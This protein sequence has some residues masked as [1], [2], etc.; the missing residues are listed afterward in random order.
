MK[1]GFIG[2]GWIGKNMADDFEERGY[3]VV[4]YALEEPYKQNKLKILDCDITFIAVPT[5]TTPAGF[6]C[7]AVRSALT[8]IKAGNT[9]VIK[10]TVLPGTTHQ[11][12]KEFPDITV[13]HSPEFLREKFAA[14]DTRNPK[15][16]IIGIVDV[17]QIG[18][19]EHVLEALPDSQY[20]R[21]IGAE[22]AECV[23]YI[24]N[25]FL[26]T[27]LVFFN[28]MHDMVKDNGG[29]WP[30]V[31]EAVTKDDRIG[32]SHTTVVGNGGKRGAGGHC[33]IKDFAA[34]LTLEGFD[35]DER[36]ALEAIQ[37]VNNNLL[38]LTHKDTDLLADVVG[39]E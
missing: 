36:E 29:Y 39:W 11:L 12:Q 35:E 5:P 10:S 22:S 32:E 34:M 8:L 13:M 31:I 33:F 37:H 26:Y 16:N 15:R 30:D 1:I 17:W 7:D 19:A 24:G 20:N 2:Q 25:N 18:A 23:K 38:I 28:M 21:I 14:E 27:K 9:A 3:R 4:R 6:S